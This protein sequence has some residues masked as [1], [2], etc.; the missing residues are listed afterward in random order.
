MRKYVYVF[1][2]LLSVLLPMEVIHADNVHTT[3]I[4]TLDLS[5]EASSVKNEAEGWEWTAN[6]DGSYTL[7]LQDVTIA[8][9]GDD[10]GIKRQG[11]KTLR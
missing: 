10:A 1:C 2:M 6:A 9:T 11:I 5:M 8:I 4:T 3:R 7:L